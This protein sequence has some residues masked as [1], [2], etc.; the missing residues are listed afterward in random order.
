MGFVEDLTACSADRLEAIIAQGRA[1]SGDADTKALL[2]IAL[3]NEINVAELA[4]S[5]VATTPEV[6]AKLAFARQAGDEAGHFQL[7]A[8]RLRAQGF[9]VDA[10]VPP[11]RNPL[12]A[13]IASLS[14]TV[15]RVAASL[16]ALE[17]I[18][19][20]VNE[21]FIAYCRARGDL[22]TVR[23]Y[24]EIIQPEEREH[25]AIGR[26]L[27]ARYAVSDASQTAATSVVDRVLEIAASTRAAAATRLGVACF[28]GC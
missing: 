4:A 7:V 23:L 2:Q 20:G 15:E 11:A 8:E 16:F 26:V 25:Q 3:V 28:P 14:S 24:D 18:A 17:A 22:E 6:D 21:N 12:F 27:L 5:W 1:L 9:D 19:Y 13:Y 10:F